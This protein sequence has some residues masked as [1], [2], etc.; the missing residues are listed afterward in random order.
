MGTIKKKKEKNV[1]YFK[2]EEVSFEEA[3]I[4][5]NRKIDSTKNELEEKIE[6][7]KNILENKKDIY[8]NLIIPEKK[9][10]YKRLF[11]K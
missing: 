7:I 2:G 5:L 1:M 11:G 6:G 3:I 8:F 9:P 4:V 10:W